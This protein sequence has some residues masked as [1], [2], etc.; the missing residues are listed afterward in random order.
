[1]EHCFPLYIH[2]NVHMCNL[3]VHFIKGFAIY[4]LEHYEITLY[5]AM[6]NFK[7]RSGN[8]QFIPTRE[9]SND[10]LTSN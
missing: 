8:Y 6:L 2:F 1:M 4:I 10:E 9:S 7:K 3:K 5:T